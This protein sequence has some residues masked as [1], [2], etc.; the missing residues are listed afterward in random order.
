LDKLTLDFEMS[1]KDAQCLMDLYSRRVN[2]SQWESRKISVCR[3]NYSIECEDEKSFY[4]GFSPNWLKH[5]SYAVRGRVEFNPNKMLDDLIFL[6]T[7]MELKSKVPKCFLKVIKFDLAIDLPVSRDKVQLVKDKRTYEE[8]CNSSSDRTQYLGTR[9][10]HGRVKVY[11]K[12]L[13]SKLNI[14]LT[15]VELTIDY[16]KRSIDE[17]KK[18]L[19]SLYV[20]DSFQIPLNING[21]DKLLLIA[22]L[23][24]IALIKELPH[25]KRAKIKAYL[26]D[27]QLNLSLDINKYNKV[28]ANIQE[29][30][31]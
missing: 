5:D 25:T 15:R 30:I 23:S 26:A 21:T 4:I 28:L 27:M 10:S 29:Y 8:Y 19:P 18:M 14:D 1:K 9:N 31:N 3:Y 16:N 24:D 6:N 22:I 13:E 20:L 11:N 7:Y 12:S 17:V 2:F